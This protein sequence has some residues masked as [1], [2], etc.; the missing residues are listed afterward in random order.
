M[1]SVVGFPAAKI[2]Y[3]GPGGATDSAETELRNTFVAFVSFCKKSSS[4]CPL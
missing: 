3:D 1:I 2:V 4:L